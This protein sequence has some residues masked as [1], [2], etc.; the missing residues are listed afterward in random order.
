MSETLEITLEPGFL[1]AVCAGAVDS[2]TIEEFFTR[3]PDAA[4]NARV[5]KIL[6]DGR[7]AIVQLST[8]KRFEYGCRIEEVFRG[9]KL[10]CVLSPRFQ[11]PDLFGENVAVNRG[12]NMRVFTTLEEAY[13][14]LKVRPANKTDAGDA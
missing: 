6:F 5:S 13:E 1:R 4:R 11:S 2:S 3:M 14:W 9:L 10:A 8:T 12:A 7:R